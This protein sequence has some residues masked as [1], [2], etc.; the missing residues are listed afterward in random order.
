[1]SQ[2][3]LKALTNAANLREALVELDSMAAGASA[4]TLEAVLIAD[5]AI[6]TLILIVLRAGP[7]LSSG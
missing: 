4:L 3:A 2:R 1:M 5:V 6:A 7:F